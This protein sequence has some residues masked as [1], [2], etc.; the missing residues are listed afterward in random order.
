MPISF[1]RYAGVIKPL[2][3]G[4]EIFYRMH[5]KGRPF[6]K[7][8]ASSVIFDW[9]EYPESIKEITKSRPG[10]SAW[11]NPAHL[12]QY[13]EEMGWDTT[14]PI[15]AFKGRKVGEGFD[16]EPLVEPS[17]PPIEKIRWEDFVDRIEVTPQALE[18]PRWGE[19]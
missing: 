15:L 10:Y 9:N 11:A 3:M 17:G 14:D 16:G 8:D 7:A 19:D 18:F 12:R 5:P 13:V 4:P 6:S 2:P 1:H